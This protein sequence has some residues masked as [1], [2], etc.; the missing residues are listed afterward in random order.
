V[1]THAQLGEFAHDAARNGLAMQRDRFIKYARAVRSFVVLALLL[2]ATPAV[3]AQAVAVSVEELA[4]ASDAVVRA[5]VTSTRAQ[6]S[7]DGLRIYTTVELRRDEVI[8]GDVPR[9]PRVVVPGGVIARMGQRVD[10]APSF[11]PGEQVV[12]FL[13]R[14]GADTFRV[15]GLAQGKFTVTGGVATP[16]L[17]QLTFIQT[18]VRAGERRAEEM[19]LSELERRVR[20]TR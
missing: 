1:F 9:R 11:T 12:V 5:Q 2:A 17:S 16:D 7:E 14:A 8:A 15:T 3:A 20:S 10:A 19:P 13:R 6:L 4:R 18:P